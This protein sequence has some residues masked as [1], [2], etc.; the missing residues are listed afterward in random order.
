MLKYKEMMQHRSWFIAYVRK[1]KSIEVIYSP[2]NETFTLLD[3]KTNIA[4][5]FKDPKE[6]DSKFLQLLD[7]RKLSVS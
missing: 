2:I 3:V 6:F 1:W 5:D 7:A 4:I